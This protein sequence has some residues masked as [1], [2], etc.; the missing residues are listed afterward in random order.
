LTTAIGLGLIL[1]GLFAPA[2]MT[3]QVKCGL[4]GCSLMLRF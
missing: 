4:T 2:G 1:A 3:R